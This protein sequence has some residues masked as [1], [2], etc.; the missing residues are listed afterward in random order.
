MTKTPK[1]NYPGHEELYQRR[2]KEGAFGWDT[3]ET[4]RENIEAIELL[5]S[6]VQ[7]SPSGAMLELGCGAGNL[8][9]HFAQSGWNAHGIDIS[10]TAI[11]WAA[12][13]ASGL[14]LDVD[15]RVGSVLDL[16]GYA[17]NSFDLVLDGHCLHCIIGPDRQT[18]F[19][20]AKR[21]LKPLGKLLVLTMA[22]DA[23]E[24]P[25]RGHYDSASRCQVID[26]T[27]TR[28]FGAPESILKEIQN[29]GFSVEYKELRPRSNANETDHLLIAASLS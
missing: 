6:K 26:D 5:L 18:F 14:G 9:A 10:P 17:P 1:T 11:E 3:H 28:Y 20:E 13:R 7:P 23:S 15:V 16:N 22:G 19:Q 27:M 8:T 12:E 2:R 29:A 25:M 24:V 21:V 4:T